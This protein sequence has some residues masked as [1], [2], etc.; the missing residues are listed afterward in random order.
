MNDTITYIKTSEDLL[1]MLWDSEYTS[2]FFNHKDSETPIAFK[3]YDD[4]RQIPYSIFDNFGTNL[5]NYKYFDNSKY[6]DMFRR[7]Y[8]LDSIVSIARLYN[9]GG[10]SFSKYINNSSVPRIDI[11]GV[12]HPSLSKPVKNDISFGN[13]IITGPNAGG[14]STLIK[15]VILSVILSQ[16]LTI[17]NCTS[18]RMTPFY[19]I[20]SQMN[21]PDCKGK[22]SLF[23]AEMKRSKKNLDKLEEL[24]GKFSVMIMDEIFNSTNP[25][26]GISGAYAIMKKISSYKSNIMVFTTHYGYL[27]RLS[28]ECNFKNVKMCVNIEDDGNIKF[29]YKLSNGVSRQYIALDLLK[30]NGFDP[31]LIDIALSVKNKFVQN[32]TN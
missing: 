12:Y 2:I 14:K 11:K 13:V 6:I 3:E 10:Y 1:S 30:L 24:D 31:E 26:E 23:E 5:K 28:K 22:E 9:K 15:S 18:I 32:E 21:V 7:I 4:T 8:Q 25:V 16:T 29:P 20:N 19:Y 27:T 17:S